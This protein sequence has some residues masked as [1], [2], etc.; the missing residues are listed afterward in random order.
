MGPAQRLLFGIAMLIL[1]AIGFVAGRT[2]L[3]PNRAIHQPIAFNHRLHAENADCGTCHE[4][5]QRAAH[6]GLPGLA[7][8]LQCHE[9][10][11]TDNPEEKKIATLAASGQ[12][13]V[14][15]KLFRLPD[16]VFYTH[17]R[18]VGIAA[19]ECAT[20]HGAIARA[21]SPPAAPLIGITMN[22]C[23]D[24]HRTRGITTDCTACH[25]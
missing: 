5:A 7:T 22:F 14:F 1:A 19:L 16:N 20:C 8:C 2:L 10:P 11:M 12:D 18:H 21:E 13:Q 23:L 15:R 3:R 25:R 17:R 24:C 6:S 9:D 4:F